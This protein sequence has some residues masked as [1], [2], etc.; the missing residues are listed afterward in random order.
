MIKEK[1]KTAIQ[2]INL[3][4]RRNKV[5]ALCFLILLI[6]SAGYLFLTK[7]DKEE[8]GSNKYFCVYKVYEKDKKTIAFRGDGDEWEITNEQSK[9]IKDNC[10]ETIWTTKEKDK[11]AQKVNNKEEDNSKKSE[12]Q[13][14][15]TE[16]KETQKENDKQEDNSQ[17]PEQQEPK[18]DNSVPVI[19]NLMIDFDSY[20]ASTGKAG[21]FMF[22]ASQDK[23]FL[24]YGAVVQGPDGKKTLPTFE[25]RTDPNAK[26]YAVA[27]GVVMD[28]RYQTETGDYEIMTQPTKNSN[29][30][31]IYDHIKNVTLKKDDEITAGQPLGT[32]GSWNGNLGRTELMIVSISDKM[33]YC[34]FK[35]FDG[36]LLNTYKQKVSDLMLDWET[37]K[38]DSTIYNEAADIWPGCPKETLA[39]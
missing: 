18:T 39:N 16:N 7:K 32:V 13:E 31:V 22:D 10:P 5:L 12:Q 27:N 2:K 26:A 14:F 35:F 36:S 34:P 33:S 23:V 1:I 6:S 4:T 29:Y 11:E 8:K 17:K 15:K 3:K 24:E 38:G 19:K 30:M 21:A 37:F 20:N 25:Y 28:V 9:W